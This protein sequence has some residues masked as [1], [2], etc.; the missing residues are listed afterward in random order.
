MHK[1]LGLE[2]SGFLPFKMI[3]TL[4]LWIRVFG[5]R[6]WALVLDCHATTIILERNAKTV[7]S[8]TVLHQTMMFEVFMNFSDVNLQS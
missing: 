4:M 3:S 8:F 5:S 2:S 7:S 6:V 1:R